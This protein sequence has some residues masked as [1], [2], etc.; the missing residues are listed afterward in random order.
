MLDHLSSKP[1]V[2]DTLDQF[3][4][5]VPIGWK[6][7]VELSNLLYNTYRVFDLAV[8]QTQVIIYIY[9]FLH[10]FGIEVDFWVTPFSERHYI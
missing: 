7:T 5:R 10:A 8:H 9:I 6:I 4:F 2:T 3:Q 1:A